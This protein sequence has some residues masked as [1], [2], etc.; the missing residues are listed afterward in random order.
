MAEHDN[1]S[2]RR[3]RI[4]AAL[5][6]ARED[7][8]LTQA[9]AAQ[10]L[11]WSLSKLIRIEA[12][13]VGVSVSDLRALLALYRVTDR[14]TV[15]SLIES[16]RGSR[17]R[18]WLSAYRDI[19]PAQFVQFLN[20]EAAATAIRVSHPHLIP[21]LLQTEQYAA[22][23]VDSHQ[24][25]T[26]DPRITALRLERQRR[27]FDRTDPPELRFILDEEALHR[28]IGGTQVM[29]QQLQH[30]LEV[31]A[32]SN[33]AIQVIPFSAG[34]HP[35]LLTQFLL[36]SFTDDDDLLFIESAISTMISRDD[37]EMVDRYTKYFEMLRGQALSQDQTNELINSVAGNFTSAD[38]AATGGTD[39]AGDRQGV[40]E[41][42]L[43]AHKPPY[44]PANRRQ[45]RWGAT[46]A[47]PGKRTRRPMRRAQPI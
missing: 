33:V 8:P 22:A 27:L 32:R 10:R 36:L 5:R 26:Q 29:L 16:A 14:E 3:R 45:P 4:K 13:T 43:H 38:D 31:N 44:Q 15:Q 39:T 7:V 40:E 35:G 23:L 11:D 47:D 37:R 46:S 19:I 9:E 12:G 41:L 30:L 34:A 21:G 28:R 25:T 1:Q 18:S 42:T 6:K 20:Y 24:E 2:I 17:G